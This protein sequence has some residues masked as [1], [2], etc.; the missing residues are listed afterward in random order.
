MRLWGVLLVTGFPPIVDRGLLPLTAPMVWLAASVLVHAYAT[1]APPTAIAEYLERSARALRIAVL[2]AAGAAVVFAAGYGV[3]HPFSF[4]DGGF[5]WD[6]SVPNAQG[7]GRVLFDPKHGGSYEFKS[8][9]HG[10]APPRGHR[11]RAAGRRG[12]ATGLRPRLRR[13][14]R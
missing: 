5:A 9:E 4:D 1:D 6:S 13:G 7:S 10:P 11:R 8:P 12:L 3:T 2:A 14:G